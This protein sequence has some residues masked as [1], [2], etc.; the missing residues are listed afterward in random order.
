[1]A[2]AKSKPKP[3]SSK[4]P[5]KGYS[6]EDVMF[7]EATCWV[8]QAGRDLVVEEGRMALSQ[9]EALDLYK[10]LRTGF[11]QLLK[12]GTKVEKKKALEH[13]SCLKMMPLR[14]H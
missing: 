6:V 9:D 5:F 8:V 10:R 14:I 1:M 11:S 4:S 3:R 2:K 12:T 13:L 7:S